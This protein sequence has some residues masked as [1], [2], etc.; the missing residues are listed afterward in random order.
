ME[1]VR[2]LT[3][4][5]LQIS[6]NNDEEEVLTCQVLSVKQTAGTPV[7]NF[8]D[9]HLVGTAVCLHV[10]FLSLNRH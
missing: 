10:V 2:N 5:K 1:F 8:V 9:M 3:L 7:V 6:L 4:A